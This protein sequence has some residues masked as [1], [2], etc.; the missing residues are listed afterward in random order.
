MM[1]EIFSKISI[2]INENIYIKNPES[3]ELGQKIVTGGID[4]MESLGFDDFTIR[5]LALEIGST[6]ASIYRYFESKHK[7][8]LYLTS[9][10]WGWMEYQLVFK[11]ANIKSPVDRL[12][13][14]IKLV[15]GG[16]SLSGGFS[17]MNETKLER[18]IISESTKAYLNKSVD[19]INTDGVF[20]TYKM[21]VERLSRIILEINPNYKYSH[22][23]VSTIIE[24]AHLQRYYNEHLP[25]LTDRIKGQ[26]AVSDFY[27][28]LVQKAIN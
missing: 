5:K 8:L 14:A 22:M 21:I 16:L 12:L 6:E 7:L 3:T 19:Q 25:R 1:E 18:I 11:L 23:L 13:R 4:L 20:K 10:Y 2:S 17:H 27:V 15:S 24:G 28:E 26:D 9:W